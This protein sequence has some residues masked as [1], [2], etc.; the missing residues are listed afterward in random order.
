MKKFFVLT[1]VIAMMVIA[2][3]PALAADTTVVFPL[4]GNNYVAYVGSSLDPAYDMVWTQDG[5]LWQPNLPS[6]QD[7]Q[8]HTVAIELVA[9][10][11]YVF[12]GVESTLNVDL[13]CDGEPDWLAAETEDGKAFSVAPDAGTIE[14]NI[15]VVWAT[16]WSATPS[17][18]SEI[19]WDK[20][21]NGLIDDD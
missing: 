2:V 14:N 11:S 17:G 8:T 19:Y 6:K 16:I 10:L 18:G 5:R 20:N 3:T 1:L 12:N 9:G 13:N 15:R 7:R 21:G 4:S